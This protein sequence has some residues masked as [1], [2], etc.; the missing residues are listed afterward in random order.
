MA[1]FEVASR[2][3]R[4]LHGLRTL[5]VGSDSETTGHH[6]RPGPVLGKHFDCVKQVAG[7]ENRFA[8]TAL[9]ARGSWPGHSAG[10]AD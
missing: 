2:G 7:A 6:L 3:V 9:R 5:V 8:A 1:E 4:L 10:I